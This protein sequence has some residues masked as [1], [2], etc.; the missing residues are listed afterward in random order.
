MDLLWN[1]NGDLDISQNKLKLATTS[2]QQ[3]KQRLYLR[4]FTNQ[5]EW[6]F[7]TQLGIPWITAGKEMQILAKG[8]ESFTEAIIRKVILETEGVQKINSFDISYDPISREGKIN[9]K[10]QIIG[11]VEIEIF[12]ELF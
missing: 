12:E 6:V 7:N 2:S 5:G 9:V 1:S 8:S 10:V 11:D 4:L 3:I